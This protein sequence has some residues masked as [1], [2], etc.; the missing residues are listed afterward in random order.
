[1]VA[2][3]LADGFEEIEALTAVDLLRRVKIDVRT[4]G[5]GSKKVRGAH[6]IYVEAD[7]LIED[8]DFNS[9]DMFV[10]PGGMPGTNNLKDCTLLREE[11]LKAK[12]KWICAICAAPLVLGDLGLLE[13]RKCTIYPG[14][15]E[16][17]IGGKPKKDSVVIDGNI[18]TSRG[19][20]KAMDFALTLVDILTDK[21]TR[22]NLERN[23]VL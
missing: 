17:L 12:D 18:V 11:L 9:V 14:M 8:L 20:G 2:I 10:L 21:K 19:P 23:L 1:M 15:E 6:N 7:T 22:T 4:V 3:F 16:Y 5:V 13:G